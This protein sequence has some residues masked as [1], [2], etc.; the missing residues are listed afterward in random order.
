MADDP[1]TWLNKH[2]EAGIHLR[3]EA[4]EERAVEASSQPEESTQKPAAP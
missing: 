1:R 2:I 4:V 3:E